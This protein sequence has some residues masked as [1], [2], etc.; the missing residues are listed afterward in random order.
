MEWN[1]VG[2]GVVVFG[3][4]ISGGCSDDVDSVFI[5]DRGHSL[6]PFAFQK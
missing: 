3:V 5:G 1:F 6:S 2:G 4:K